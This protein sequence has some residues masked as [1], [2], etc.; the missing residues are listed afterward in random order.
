[1]IQGLK[2]KVVIVTGGGHGIGRA[3][4]LGFGHAGSHVVVAD[5]DKPA[6]DQVCAEVM[7]QNGA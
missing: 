7:Q 1:M 6:A 3:Y 2:E 4:C 5:I